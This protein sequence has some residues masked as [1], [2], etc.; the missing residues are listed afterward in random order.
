MNPPEISVVL[1][2]QNAV[3][4]VGQCLQA[5]QKQ[6]EG[7]RAEVIVA[8]CSTDGTDEVIRASFPAVRLL[9]FEQSMSLP[10][11]LREALRRADGR[12][13]VITDPHCTFPP[14]WLAKIRRA[15]ESEY[16]VIGGAVEN[17]RADE[18][19]GWACHFADYGAFMLPAQR[20]VTTLL[21]GNHISY[22]RWVIERQLDSMEDGFWKVFFHWDLARQG[23]PFLFDPELVIHHSCPDNLS[24]FL[25]RYFRSGRVFAAHRCKRLSPAERLLHLAGAPAL[26][27]LLLYQRLRT[28]L[29]R[30]GEQV[31]L[32]EALPLLAAF[33]TAWAAGEFSGYLFGS[34]RASE[35]RSSAE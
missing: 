26:P 13:I 10:M 22:K 16:A 11:L 23:I 34:G 8:D 2:T 31:K 15:H 9:H 33:V 27:A 7:A 18:L 21:A 24:G 35:E 3:S 19:V 32:F 25:Q 4:Y 17:G 6:T 14:D 20:R 29:G 5:L 30:T 28:G 1:A 12:V